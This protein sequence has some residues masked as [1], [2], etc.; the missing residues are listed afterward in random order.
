MLPDVGE[1]PGEVL[2]HPPGVSHIDPCHTDRVGCSSAVRIKILNYNTFLVDDLLVIEIAH[3]L[4][5]VEGQPLEVV[6]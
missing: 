4:L 5:G 6:I 2:R 3:I 1:V